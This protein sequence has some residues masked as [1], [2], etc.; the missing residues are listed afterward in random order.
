MKQ[1]SVLSRAQQTQC[2]AFCSASLHCLQCCILM[3]VMLHVQLLQCLVCN[4]NRHIL[5]LQLSHAAWVCC[6]GAYS[7]SFHRRTCASCCPHRPPRAVT[8]SQRHLR[9]QQNSRSAF[10]RWFQAACK[11]ASRSALNSACWPAGYGWVVVAHAGQQVAGGCSA[12]T[13]C[14]HAMFAVAPLHAVRAVSHHCQ[15][16][17]AVCHT[18]TCWRGLATLS[19]A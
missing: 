5:R 8:W 17:T 1:R 9:V 4:Q 10:R 14:L 11:Q 16:D 7:Y 6:S 2:C 18:A 3:Q 12:C 15:H 19:F 13:P